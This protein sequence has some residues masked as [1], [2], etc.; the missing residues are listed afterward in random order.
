[1][2]S[3][4]L[5]CWQEVNILVK[6]KLNPLSLLQ[7]WIC[8]FFGCFF[9]SRQVDKTICPRYNNTMHGYNIIMYYKVCNINKS[10]ITTTSQTLY[11]THFVPRNSIDFY[12]QLVVR[13]LAY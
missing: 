7:I 8:F 2:A 13:I 3:T 12:Y 1:M 5:V 11:V 6:A 9:L 10:D 4:R